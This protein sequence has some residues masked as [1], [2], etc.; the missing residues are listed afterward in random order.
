MSHRRSGRPNELCIHATARPIVGVTGAGESERLQR[1]RRSLYALV[2]ANAVS[3]FGN[4]VAVVA[5][6][7]FVLVTTGSAARTGLTAFAT[8]L[9]LA[10]GA[11]AGGSV[12]DRLGLR[13]SSVGA[14]VGAA[15]AIAGIPLLHVIGALEFWHVLVL[16]F[17]A[18]AFEAPGRAARRAMLP[19]LAERAEMPFERAN[20]I[21]TTSEHLGYVLGAPLTGVAIAT[22]GAAN[23][24]WLDAASFLLSAAILVAARVPVVAPAAERTPMLDGLRFVLRTPLLFAFFVTWVVGAFVIAPLAPVVL[25]VY[26]STE[27]GGAGALAAS[28]TAYG[29]GGLVGTAGFGFV[30]SALPRRHFYRATWVVYA[31]LSLALVVVPPLGVL[32]VVLFAIGLVAGMYDPFETTIHQELIPVSLR[33]RAFAILIAAEMIVVPP[34]M[35]INGVLIERFGLRAALMLFA[36]GNV[37][38]ALFAFANRPAK[39]L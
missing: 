12:V 24:L 13:R 39:T 3:Q 22:I 21:S 19:D 2:A 17:F 9:P 6:P 29:L 5:L 32:L 37:L 26:A 4:V 1:V 33:A 18:G 7:W 31:L 27:L 35:L 25:P 38:L 15:A 8:T 23:A 20:S 34:S 28:V 14:D 36:V 16:A 11:L 10:V 30:G